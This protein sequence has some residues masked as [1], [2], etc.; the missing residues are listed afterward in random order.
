MVEAFFEEIRAQL[1]KGESVKLSGY[2]NFQLRDKPQRPDAT[3][4]RRRNPNYARRVVTFHPSQK[5]KTM[6][7]KSYHGKPQT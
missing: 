1:E 3:Q 2:G 5:L 6:V 4:D 7:E